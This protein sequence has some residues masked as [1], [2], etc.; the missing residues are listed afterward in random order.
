MGTREKLLHA[1]EVSALLATK[2]S[3]I[4]RVPAWLREVHNPTIKSGLPWIPF[5]AIDRLD[6]EV[7]PTSRVFEFGGGGSTMWLAKRAGLVVTVE[8]DHDWFRELEKT[9]GMLSNVTLLNRPDPSAEDYV[10]A[11]ND[12]ALGGDWDIVVVDG[13]ERVRCLEAAARVVRPGGVIVLDDTDRA[14]YARAFELLE[15]WPCDT[16][17]GLAPMKPMPGQT[18]FWRRPA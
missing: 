5:D 6:S 4:R 14:K 9:C 7:R 17:R 12:P 1:R 11:A 13:R 15:G 10:S 3:Q 8:H 2:P 18:T 16:Y